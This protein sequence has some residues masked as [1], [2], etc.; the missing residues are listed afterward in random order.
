MNEMMKA[1]TNGIGGDLGRPIWRQ[2]FRQ[3]S[4]LAGNP[5]YKELRQDTRQLAID[6]LALSIFHSQVILP[7]HGSAGFLSGTRRYGVTRIRLGKS[8]FTKQDATKSGRI[9]KQFFAIVS[10]Y[11]IEISQLT[12]TS[13]DTLIK[14][15]REIERSDG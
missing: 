12:F 6:I 13:P 9:T 5:A 3:Q 14:T 2:F 10:T 8:H 1:L 4:A 15:V 7:L 11:G